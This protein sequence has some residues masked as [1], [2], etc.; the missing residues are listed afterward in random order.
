[1]EATMN[2]LRTHTQELLETVLHGQEIVITYHGQ[3]YAKLVP[4]QPAETQKPEADHQLFGIWQDREDLPDVNRYI[5]Q[6]RKGA[7]IL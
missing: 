4:V 7:N 3:P 2:D 6:L 1:M 5:R